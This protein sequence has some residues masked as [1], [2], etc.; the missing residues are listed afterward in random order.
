[1]AVAVERLAPP[2]LDAVRYAGDAVRA[3]EAAAKY[4]GD[5]VRSAE[6]AAVAADADVQP[7]NVPPRVLAML[8]TLGRR[9][10]PREAT[11]S[12]VAEDP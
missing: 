8:I 6:A 4:T 7:D 12:S 9:T 3:A 1:L 5:A 2:A 11:T 10:T